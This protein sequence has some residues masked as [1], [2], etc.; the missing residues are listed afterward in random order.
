METPTLTQRGRR[1]LK[2]KNLL[3]CLCANFPIKVVTKLSLKALL[4]QRRDM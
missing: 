2:P 1:D 3:N 4:T